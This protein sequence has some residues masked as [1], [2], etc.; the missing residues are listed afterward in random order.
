MSD[1]NSLMTYVT[2]FSLYDT[3]IVRANAVHEW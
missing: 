1:R 3:L 2:F